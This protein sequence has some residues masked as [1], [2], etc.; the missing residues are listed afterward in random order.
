MSAV[1]CDKPTTEAAPAAESYS[2]TGDST[3]SN[4]PSQDRAGDLQRVRLT[5]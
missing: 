4:T 5:S 3:A 2:S 1:A